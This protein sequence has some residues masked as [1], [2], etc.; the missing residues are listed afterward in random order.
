MEEKY[1][2]Q[3]IHHISAAPSTYSRELGNGVEDGVVKW[4]DLSKGYGFIM[5]PN[6]PE[7]SEDVFVHQTSLPP[8]PGR[9]GLA[10][11]EV[12]WFRTSR[13]EGGR[14]RA[15]EITG[16]YGAPV[17]GVP[18]SMLPV[19]PAAA[20]AFM[21]AAMGAISG[22][23]GPYAAMPRE[24][25]PHTTAQLPPGRYRGTAKWFNTQKGFGFIAPEDGTEDIFVHQ[26]NML[27]VEGAFRSLAEKENL[28]F[29]I[30]DEPNQGRA[31]RKSNNVTG[32]G[33]LPV[34]GVPRPAGLAGPGQMMGGMAASPYGVPSPYGAAR[35]TM[36]AYAAYGAVYGQTPRPGMPAARPAAAAAVATP[37][38][39]AY[40]AYYA[41]QAAQAAQ[42]Y[43]QQP[44]TSQPSQPSVTDAQAQHAAA[45]QQYYA[46]QAA[47]AAAASGGAGAG[48]ARPQ[49][50]AAQAQAT[51]DHT[52]AWE[53]YYAQMAA[54]GLQ[55]QHPTQ[56]PE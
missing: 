26:S 48:Q 36:P 39:P 6:Q 18:D 19:A 35:P 23:V 13:E 25:P 21:A 47:A 45:W 30:M 11:K 34:V 10:D 4:F 2:D 12:V 14:L 43:A 1:N 52:A 16:P 31:K 3:I 27:C 53:A 8:R 46:Q 9:K 38:D 20:A 56:Q 15:N 40:A 54:M 32:P 51:Q 5:R 28:E 33:G 41:A 37:Q 49:E 17:I 42:Y 24:F 55:P 22:A 7:G 50:G 44:L 29:S